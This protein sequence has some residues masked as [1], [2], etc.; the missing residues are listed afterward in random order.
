MNRYKLAKTCDSATVSTPKW[1]SGTVFVLL[2]IGI[3]FLILNAGLAWIFIKALTRPTCPIP[4]P[5]PGGYSYQEHWLQTE[6]GVVIRI[7]YY[8]SQNN[9]AII[10]LG[11]LT[12]SLGNK[13]PPVDFLLQAGYGIVQVD[14]RACSQPPAPVT[15]GAHEIYDAE[16]ALSFLH[17]VPGVDPDRIGV[18]GFSMGGATAIR[19]MARH[20]AIQSLVR[21]G[22]YASLEE[23]FKPTANNSSI[24]VIFRRFSQW[25]FQWHTGI[26]P[27]T[28]SPI[29]DLQVI[30]GRPVF[31]IYG[32]MEV[33]LGRAQ[34]EAASEPKEMWV[35]PGGTHGKN[36]LVAPQEYRQ[37]VIEF[38]NRTLY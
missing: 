25:M 23:L 31:F 19:L 13:I 11:G 4:Q 7:W 32:E 26:N 22:G 24:E 10:T 34:F 9:A 2:S 21:D 38:F 36:H 12:G 30:K 27:K 15:L 3:L 17:T 33:E 37:K 5:H 14:T 28:I 18:M 20:T 16:A 6:D 35:V 1:L 8:P 29:D